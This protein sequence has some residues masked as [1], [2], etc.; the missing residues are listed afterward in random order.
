[1]NESDITLWFIVVPYYL[2]TIAVPLGVVA[3][4]V[5]LIWFMRRW[6]AVHSTVSTEKT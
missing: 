6:R 3:V 4:G 2:I 5:G 1:M